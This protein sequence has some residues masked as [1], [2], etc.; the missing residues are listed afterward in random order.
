MKLITH[1]QRSWNNLLRCGA[2]AAC[3]GVALA[4]YAQTSGS[5]S[6]SSASSSNDRNSSA[7]ASSRDSDKSSKAD[8][9]F[10]R[11]LTEA[12]QRE[13]AIAQLGVERAT[14]P[15]VKAFAQK[16]VTDHQ[17]MHREFS[18]VTSGLT[19]DLAASTAM[20]SS[21][22]SMDDTASTA[23]GSEIKTGTAGSDYTSTNTGGTASTTH[24]ASGAGQ[25]S[26]LASSAGS[27][28]AASATASDEYGRDHSSMSRNGSQD[29]AV[30]KLMDEKSGEDFDKAFVKAMVKEHKQAEDLLK[31][32]AE[33]KD[34]SEAIRSF[35]NKNLP[36]IRAHLAEVQQLEKSID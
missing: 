28:G 27:S 2:T 35:A 32:A 25:T 1:N 11:K 5:S 30:R 24:P 14:N 33:D 4:G 3:L 17:N 12:N 20:R 16:M 36:T 8:Q 15:Q 13:M 22:G 10:I 23:S 34:H 18:S 7:Y 21:T 26:G 9:K 6:G 29:R 31:D 19:S